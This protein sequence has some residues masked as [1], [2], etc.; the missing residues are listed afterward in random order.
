MV[1]FV[2]TVGIEG[3]Y[4]VLKCLRCQR[5]FWMVHWER[6]ISHVCPYCTRRAAS[7]LSVDASNNIV[8]CVVCEKVIEDTVFACDICGFTIC[9]DCIRVDGSWLY[10]LDCW[11]K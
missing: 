4:E 11:V 9:L 5:I 7:V 3:P 10:C 6:S 8:N 2:E 1:K